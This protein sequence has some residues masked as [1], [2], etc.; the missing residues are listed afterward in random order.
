M[1][2]NN[3]IFPWRISE[4][5]YRYM[6]RILK[7]SEQVDH[8]M[9]GQVCRITV[10]SYNIKDNIR[11]EYHTELAKDRL[12]QVAVLGIEDREFMVLQS[13]LVDLNEDLI[14]VGPDGKILY[15]D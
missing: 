10:T 6:S 14:V 15:Q 7:Y 5:A 3:T 8:R 12:W 13:Q 11:S 4:G 2:T 9:D 1:K